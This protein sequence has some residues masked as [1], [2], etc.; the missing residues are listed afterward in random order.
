MRSAEVGAR[1][2]GTA[3]REHLARVETRNADAIE[4]AAGLLHGVVRDDGLVYAAGSGHSLAMVL[5]TFYRAGGL[6]CV[7]PVFHPALLP[8][9]GGAASTLLERVVGLADVLLEQASPTGR[10]VAVIF[11]NSGANPFPVEL[12]RGFRRAGTPVVAVVSAEHMRRAPARAGAKLAEVADHV[13]D[14]L[15]PFGDAA[16]A[17]DGHPPTAPLSSLTSTFLWNSILAR[18]ADLASG[19][20]VDLPLW[21]SA[22]VEGGDER[23]AALVARYRRR[24]PAL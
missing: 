14:T 5:E 23:N 24:I 22:N 11:S 16:Y 8:L 3:V 20:G 12:A 19:S 10:D 13:L 7:Y 4:V 17:P 1:G 21:T 18:L 2:F 15:V 6:A 9:S